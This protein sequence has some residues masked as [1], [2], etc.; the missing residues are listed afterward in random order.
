MPPARAFLGFF[1]AGALALPAQAQESV[2]LNFANAEIEAV[3]T[4]VGQMTRR[5]PARPLRISA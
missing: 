4:A 1:L 3:A 5:T 2:T